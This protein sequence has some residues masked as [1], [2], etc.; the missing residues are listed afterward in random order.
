MSFLKKRK[1]LF[2]LIVVLCLSLAVWSF[3]LNS[4]AVAHYDTGSISTGSF[5]EHGGIDNEKTESQGHT[6]YKDGCYVKDG[7]VYKSDGSLYSNGSSSA[8][9]GDNYA[10]GGGSAA[11]GTNPEDRET[12]Y[13]SSFEALTGLAGKLL[14][15]IIQLCT[16]IGDGIM[17]I[18]H[19]AIMGTE[20]E[21]IVDTRQGWWAAIFGVLIGLAVI[22]GLTALAVATGGSALP[23]MLASVVAGAI[24]KLTVPVALGVACFVYA[25][26][27]GSNM[28]EV[29]LLPLYTIGP[30]EIFKGN[31]LL[32]NPNIF[33]PKEVYV[34]YE[35]SNGNE[36][37]MPVKQFNE[38]E[39]T[40]AG[41]K[42]KNYFFYRDGDSTNT[43]ASNIV[44]TSTNDAAYELKN[45][46]SKWYYTIRNIAI[47]GLMLV[48]LYVGIRILLS[49]TA[50]EKAKYKEMIKDW[51]I[52][53]CLVFLLQYIM[54]F[55]LNFTDTLTN[56]LSSLAGE[57][58]HIAVIKDADDKLKE[59]VTTDNGFAPEV[60]QGNDVHWYTNL[61][62]KIR[63]QSQEESGST[64]YIGYAL[65]FLV[66]VLYTLIFTFTYLKR[67]LY[68]MF[69][70]IIAPLV[71][72]TYPLDKLR[73]G[74]AQAFDIWIKEY[75]INLLIQ[76]F[77]LLLY[78]VLIS[79]AIDL[80]STNIIYSLVALGFM[81][82]AEKF[83]RK[84]FGF[85]RASTPGFLGGAAGAAVTM[86]A[87]HSLEKFAGRGPGADRK[88]AL[89]GKQDDKNT[90]LNRKADSGH[91]N[92]TLFANAAAEKDDLK[93][94]NNNKNK[95]AEN[96]K[97]VPNPQDKKDL[98]DGE[99]NSKELSEEDKQKL[100]LLEKNVDE[101]RQL[102]DDSDTTAYTD[103][104]KDFAAANLAGAQ[105]ELDKFNVEHGLADLADDNSEADV[106]VENNMENPVKGLSSEEKERGKEA[107]RRRRM[108]GYV[109]RRSL[110]MAG[111]T[112]RTGVKLTTGIT[113]GMIGA[114][115]GIASGDPGSVVKN[116]TAGLY[117]GSA[118]GQGLGNSVSN[119]GK[120]TY[121]AGKAEREA[122]QQAKYG[123]DYSSHMKEQKDIEFSKNREMRRIFEE[124][125]GLDQIT[126]AKERKAAV[127][128]AMKNAIKYRQ[129]GVTDNNIII[130]AM[131]SNKD[132]KY[133]ADTSA[134][135]TNIA[136]A[137][138][139]SLSTDQEK[140]GENMRRFASVQGMSQAKVK[141]ME[142]RVRKIT[143]L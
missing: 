15:P 124:G 103:E 60:L 44:I 105:A 97:N 118:I 127:D 6:V 120:N 57:Q 81:I 143:G 132:G 36:G 110:G 119:F 41:R 55:A 59:V 98:I 35:D 82:P 142:R 26:V 109:G 28:Q 53:I 22:V 106:S 18:I 9:G 21:I 62:G 58:H 65:C 54:V 89:E 45:T 20:S 140:Y 80:S 52:G 126:D 70:T 19:K 8:S 47:I 122:I 37:Q 11:Q 64:A 32:F 7:K 100:S 56:L 48:L 141:D 5:Q 40:N 73:D 129:E 14:Q 123:G 4:V 137:K 111:K 131:K 23:A 134:S 91:N 33:N 67:L 78:V 49:S 74:K 68:L 79:M 71:A 46:I 42:V 113:G 13:D 114:A 25:G 104:E 96:E 72:C 117:A 116:T 84:M 61:M 107:A 31:I 69:L 115:A 139:A 27:N 30:E 50:S 2:K 24:G 133:N 77:H 51:V 95:K 38:E 102:A 108:W 125:L 10:P 88:K 90:F 92:S 43:D 1:F 135:A 101:A 93:D 121:N 87:I 138:L 76:P 66:L 130:R 94:D 34:K 99:E 16:S 63:I 128:Q 112:L 86:S 136:A 75:T 12:L 83:L 17:N 29:N 3:G 85:D 39:S